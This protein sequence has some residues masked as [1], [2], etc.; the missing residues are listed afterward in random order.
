MIAERLRPDPTAC[1]WQ[2]LILH[3]RLRIS[4]FEEV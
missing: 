1:S 3:L 4:M 2:L